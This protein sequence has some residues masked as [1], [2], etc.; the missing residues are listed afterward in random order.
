MKI[1]RLIGTIGTMF[2]LAM[3]STTARAEEN[4][5]GWKNIGP[6]LSE[7]VSATIDFQVERDYQA[8]P[9]GPA[10]FKYT[11]KPLWVNVHR[12]GLSSQDHVFV[13]IISYET[14]CYRGNCY[15]GAQSIVERNLDFAD[16]G[17]FTGEMGN[18]VLDSQ[19]NDGYALSSKTSQ[20]QELV[21]WINGRLY[22]DPQGR[23]LQ[24]NMRDAN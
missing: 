6:I 11:A 12:T 15:A 21:I 13:Q 7:D 1:Q 20:R 9:S 4:N 14:N 22:K 19:I 24:L 8:R 2:S 23:N 5:N 17:H 18:L 10:S 16:A 3:A